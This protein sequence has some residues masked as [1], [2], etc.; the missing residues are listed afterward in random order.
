MPVDEKTDSSSTLAEALDDTRHQIT[1]DDKIADPNPEALDSY[2]SIE[3]HGGVG[4]SDL[5][6]GEE[7]RRSSLEI[8]GASCLK[9]KTKA[10]SK[11]S[12][13]DYE[14]SQQYSHARKGQGHSQYASANDWSVSVSETAW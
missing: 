11:A 1:D 10:C 8:P 2:R 7:G 13:E 12:P 9:V 3:Y 14:D 6:K 5:R 4:I